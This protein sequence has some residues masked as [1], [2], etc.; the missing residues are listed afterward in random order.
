MDKWD[1][2]LVRACKKHGNIE[3]LRYDIDLSEI[4][5]FYDTYDEKLKISGL[6]LE[7]GRNEEEFRWL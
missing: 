3:I 7:I 5:E 2:L 1:N 6:P 4:I